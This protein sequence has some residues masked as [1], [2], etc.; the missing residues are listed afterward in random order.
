MN[1]DIP[2]AIKTAIAL[3]TLGGMAK[4]GYMFRIYTMRNTAKMV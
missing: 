1:I 4:G 2:T 3:V